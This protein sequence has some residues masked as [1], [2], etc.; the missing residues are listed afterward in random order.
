[1]DFDELEHAEQERDE[2][3]AP[4]RVAQEDAEEES[5]ER[6]HFTAILVASSHGGAG[7][8]GMVPF[9]AQPHHSAKEVGVRG[10]SELVRLVREEGGWALLHAL[11]LTWSTAGYQDYWQAI[12]EHEVPRKCDAWVH[13]SCLKR[14]LTHE[15]PKVLGAPCASLATHPAP[16]DSS[17]CRLDLIEQSLTIVISTS[18]AEHHCNADQM[19]QILESIQRNAA[20]AKCRKLL[21]F[22]A[23]PSHDEREQ[24]TERGAVAKGGERWVPQKSGH[25][26]KAYHIY[27]EVLRE[28][29]TVCHPAMYGVEL[30]FLP[31]WGHL[32][33]TVRHALDQV[34]TPF[35]C[36]HQHDLLVSDRLTPQ[37]VS[38]VL[39]VLAQREANYVLLNRDVNFASRSTEY[40]QACGKS[41]WSVVLVVRLCPLLVDGS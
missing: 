24:A 39:R 22:D 7:A 8:D 12:L 31:H 17:V 27:I 29:S 32:V 10:A 3:L 30:V 34:T 16:A 40:F 26:E 37:H 1:M 9:R 28:A 41:P 6:L 14:C 35:V 33:G 13:S 20:L 11:E 25:L 2:E 4:V 36:L 38:G 15:V 5:A 18:P 19:F 23:L 21:V